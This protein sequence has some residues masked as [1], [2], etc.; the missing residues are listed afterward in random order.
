M[1]H[2]MRITETITAVNPQELAQVVERRK[3]ELGAIGIHYGPIKLGNNLGHTS[4]LL[5]GDVTYDVTIDIDE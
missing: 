3:N 5:T 2:I 4:A 1:R